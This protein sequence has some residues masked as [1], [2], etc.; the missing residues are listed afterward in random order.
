MGSVANGHGTISIAGVHKSK[1]IESVSS[2]AQRHVNYKSR[3]GIIKSQCVQLIQTLLMMQTDDDVNKPKNSQ[4]GNKR[5]RRTEWVGM[6][7]VPC[8]VF[9]AVGLMWVND[10]SLQVG[11]R[12]E[13]HWVVWPNFKWERLQPLTSLFLF[14]VLSKFYSSNRPNTMITRDRSRFHCYTWKKKEN[15]NLDNRLCQT[16]AQTSNTVRITG[17][18]FKI[19]YFTVCLITITC[20]HFTSLE[21]LHY[22]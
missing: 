19:E 3:S 18:M 15:I 2:S 9:G 12:I 1:K 8:C 16:F 11:A 22:M 13:I 6:S 14:P 5:Q 7:P 20:L 4:W 21:I 10:C 17:S